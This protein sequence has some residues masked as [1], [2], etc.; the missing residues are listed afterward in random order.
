MTNTE[1]LIASF[2]HAKG[3]GST[4]RFYVGRLTGNG[5]AVVP[6]LRRRGY[7]VDRLGPSFYEIVAGP[8]AAQ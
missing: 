5:P 3:F 8:E 1:R 7:T 4:V 2:D 6:A